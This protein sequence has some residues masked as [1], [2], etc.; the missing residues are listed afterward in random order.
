MTSQ[1]YSYFTDPGQELYLRELNSQD[2]L[3]Q[4]QM[5]QMGR[6][7]QFM[8]TL[9]DYSLLHATGSAELGLAIAQGGIPASDPMVAQWVNDEL[10]T[11]ETLGPVTKAGGGIWDGMTGIWDEWVDNPIKGSTR[12]GFAAWDAAYNMLAGGAPLRAKETAQQQGISYGEGWKQQDPFF[13]EALGGVIAGEE[14]NL[15]SGW[16]P[17]SD[18]ADDVRQN[19]NI[20]MEGVERET[21]DLGA[22]ERYTKR[23]EAAPGIWRDAVSGSLEQQKMGRP[24]TEMNYADTESVIFDVDSWRGDKVRTPWSPGRIVAAQFTE[25]GTEPFHKISGTTDFMSQIFLDPVD[26]AGGLWVKAG[27]SSRKIWGAGQKLASELS[28]APDVAKAVKALPAGTPG[29]QLRLPASTTPAPRAAA[30]AD[31]EATRAFTEAAAEMKYMDGDS[32]ARASEE[33]E[34]LGIRPP[35]DPRLL[36]VLNNLTPDEVR[37]LTDAQDAGRS[38]A[39][40]QDV[41]KSQGWDGVGASAK[42]AQVNNVEVEGRLLEIVQELS[43]KKFAH[44]PD[45]VTVYRVGGL[46]AR[47][48]GAADESKKLSFTLDPNVESVNPEIISE[49]A[50]EA[51][52][53]SKSDMLQADLFRGFGLD[54]V[55]I[56]PAKVKVGEAGPVMSAPVDPSRQIME[57]MGPQ[58][59]T[60]SRTSREVVGYDDEGFAIIEDVTTKTS[61]ALPGRDPYISVDGGPIAPTQNLPWWLSPQESAK[62]VA[63]AFDPPEWFIDM[64]RQFRGEA[65]ARNVTTKPQK[66]TR[67]MPGLYEMDLPRAAGQKQQKLRIVRQGEGRNKYWEVT[68]PDGTRVENV[69][70]GDPRFTVNTEATT[71]FKTLNEATEVAKA[72]VAGPAGDDLKLYGMTADDFIASGEDFYIG[73]DIAFLKTTG[74][75]GQAINQRSVMHH[76]TKYGP[77]V[78]ASRRGN[79][80]VHVFGK[81]I[82]LSSGTLDNAS[83][84][85][86]A[87]LR[88]DGKT[89]GNNLRGYGDPVV[90]KFDNTLRW[91]EDNGVGKIHWDDETVIISDKFVGGNTKDP[92]LRMWY[93]DGNKPMHS[94]GEGLDTPTPKELDDIIQGFAES[95]RYSTEELARMRHQQ[96]L[97][98]GVRRATSENGV[99]KTFDNAARLDFDQSFRLEGKQADKFIDRLAATT[100]QAGQT[101]TAKMD[102]YLSF[103]DSQGTVV[104]NWLRKALFDA[105]S[106]EELKSIFGKWL[107]EEGGQEAL[108]PGG[109]QFGRL[110]SIPGVRPMGLN[111]TSNRWFAKQMAES[112]GGADVN[113]VED[114][115]TA[116]RLYQR[117]LP[118]YKLRRGD[119]VQAYDVEGVAI[120]GKTLS[121]DA[122][123]ERLMNLRPNNKDEAFEIQAQMSE[124]LFSQLVGYG[125]GVDPALAK[126]SAQWWKDNLDDA[127]YDAERYSRADLGSSPYDMTLMGDALTGGEDMLGGLSPGLTA[128]LWGGQLTLPDARTMRRITAETDLLGRISND[129]SWKWVTEDGIGEIHERAVIRALDTVVQRMWKPLVLLRAA[130]TIRIAM[131]DQMRL[132]AEGYNILNHPLR[133]FNYALMQPKDWRD[134]FMK[135]KVD[136]FGVEMKASNVDEMLHGDLFRDSLMSA[137]DPMTGPGAY[138]NKQH[139]PAMKGDARYAEGLTFEMTRLRGSEMTAR[140]ARS[141]SKDPVADTVKWLQG[142]G[143]RKSYKAAS[144]ELLNQEHL[145]RKMPEVVEKIRAGDTDTLTDIVSRQYAILHSRT[146]G[147]VVIDNGAGQLFSMGR[148]DMVEQVKPSEKA[149]WIVRTDGD[150]DLLGVVAGKTKIGDV[151]LGDLSSIEQRKALQ[152][153]LDTKVKSSTRFPEVVRVPKETKAINGPPTMT[154]QLDKGVS[155]MFDWFMTKPSNYL[156]RSPEFR[157][158][159]WRKMSDLYPYMDAPLKKQIDEL[160]PMSEK[161]NL[162]RA[163]RDKRTPQ[164]EGQLTDMEQ[165]DMHAK[166]FG[167]TMVESTL[168]SLNSALSGKRN[169]SDAMRLVMPFAEAWGEFLTRWGRLMVYGDRNLKNANRLRQSVMGAQRSGFFQENDYGQEV[170][171]YPAFM[172]K[173]QVALHNVLNNLPVV[174]GMMGEDVSGEVADAI[175]ATGSTE[176]LNFASSIIP[177]FGPVFQMGARYLP[178]NP[179]FD[180][181][182]DLVAPFGTEGGAVG[183]FAPAWLKRVVSAQG[184]GDDPQLSYTYN[185]T[186]IDIIRTKIDN[187]DFAGVTS[188][189]EIN[190]LVRSAESEATGLLMVRAAAAFWNP[191]SPQYTFQ[192]EDE[193]GMVWTYNNLGGAYRELEDELGEGPAYDEFYRRFG[194]MPQAFRG[195]KSYSVMDRSRSEA[196]YKFERANVELFEDYPEIAMYFDESIGVDSP[197]DHGATLNQLNEGLREGYTGEQYVYIQQDQLG[198]LWWDGVLQNAALIP[199]T[200]QKDAFLASMRDEISQSYPFWNQ[201]IPGKRQ[202]VTNDQQMAAVNRA[203]ADPELDGVP[204]LDGARIYEGYRNEVLEQIRRAGASTID[205]PKSTT[206]EAGIIA[207]KGRAWL[208]QKAQELSADYPQFEPLYRSV[209]SYEVNVTHDAVKPP[210]IDAFGEGDIFE[211]LGVSNG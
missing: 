18:V 63:R 36:T 199:D 77:D 68:L 33:L 137:H 101:S 161:A 142:K 121:V 164:I 93:E 210:V 65:V 172:T 129:A 74:K 171:N 185:S 67:R 48:A 159:Y 90:E 118:N 202:S 150:P 140:L 106:P 198:D 80:R 89:S 128:D 70:T 50:M 100:R 119:K 60:V 49:G 180:G 167:L 134:A 138:G 85:L 29:T 186:V 17:S 183:S 21:A 11:R 163:A 53:V 62:R 61:A 152:K 145:Y 20:G 208:R 28:E 151:N 147:D 35:K 131:D 51:F 209:Y 19:V 204:S 205:G 162:K 165:A 158:A 148:M 144:E 56:D 39:S 30:V 94:F 104:P 195:G 57:N 184:G 8:G 54:E 201:K 45:K 86:K 59:P 126:R 52:T 91:M 92:Q 58:Y 160:A 73:D 141:N 116:Y 75:R 135:G 32:A 6:D 154:Q 132:A 166:A 112:I 23:L 9:R 143:E 156:S 78:P 25:P 176:S 71:Q 122:V 64:H 26:W 79:A 41:L 66:P 155:R 153:I 3:L 24:L 44:L 136:V 120:E 200:G 4:R 22:N 82:D 193:T 211:E 127:L 87:A 13:F 169:I 5:E 69:P 103:L 197:Y 110:G 10:S 84:S 173:G 72:H 27:V 177:G 105:K 130:W 16:M 187:G 46:D 47:K 81:G 124:L 99:P 179:N 43:A 113:M 123:F 12:W 34:K 88:R 207:T 149:K 7:P 98:E 146:G 168:F 38:V 2:A 203:L 40:H 15:G 125:R 107:V 191:A 175:Q 117:S 192:K 55:L 174:G 102:E 194:F 189:K 139:S 1:N 114:P 37:M 76:G 206:S 115:S 190:E 83:E 133:V 96:D 178:D 111:I 157:R 14:V 31:P 181:V 108:L 196:G 182:R 170:F 42:L 95:G 188:I 109:T 97:A